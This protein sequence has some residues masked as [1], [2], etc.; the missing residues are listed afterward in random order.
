LLESG[1]GADGVRSQSMLSV[2]VS[3]EKGDRAD[4]QGVDDGSDLT[5]PRPNVRAS[6]AHD[7]GG[8]G[9]AGAANFSTQPTKKLQ[10][11]KITS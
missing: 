11:E 10:V 7:A 6:D 4:R 3:M 8:S 5:L 9:A 2:D 1:D